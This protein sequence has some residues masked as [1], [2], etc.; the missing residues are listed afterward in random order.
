MNLTIFGNDFSGL[1]TL[2]FPI[3]VII[4]LIN[5]IWLIGVFACIGVIFVGNGVRC[6]DIALKKGYTN[7]KAWF[8]FGFFLTYIATLVCLLLK[9]RATPVTA[10]QKAPTPSYE[11]YVN[12][13]LPQLTPDQIAVGVR[14][15]ECDI[16][17]PPDAKTCIICGKRLF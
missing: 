3:Y 16:V 9:S 5:L 13:P 10:A 12:P 1:N 2:F 14:C 11:R 6:R 17:N 15:T 4:L 8:F 7:E